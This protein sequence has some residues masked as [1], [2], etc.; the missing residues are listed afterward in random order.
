MECCGWVRVASVNTCDEISQHVPGAIETRQMNW[1]SDRTLDVSGY[2]CPLPTL[3]ARKALLSMAAGERLR[4]IATD[5]M[6]SIDIPHFCEESGNR[7]IA[8]AK[9]GTRL[10]F[11]IERG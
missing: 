3:K 8:T 2:Q 7:L 11:L 6:A 4:V 5:P 10:L 9:E 1:P